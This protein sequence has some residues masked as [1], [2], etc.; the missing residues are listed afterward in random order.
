[1]KK[2]KTFLVWLIFGY[3]TTPITT[4]LKYN[5]NNLIIL[6]LRLHENSDNTFDISDYK[7]SIPNTFL[8]E[9]ERIKPFKV[10]EIKGYIF[11][12]PSMADNG[13][14][15]KI[16]FMYPF[17]FGFLG[18]EYG[19]WFWAISCCIIIN[20]Y[21]WINQFKTHHILKIK[22]DGIHNDLN[23]VEYLKILRLK[24]TL[25]RLYNFKNRALSDYENNLQEEDVRF[26][27]KIMED[28]EFLASEYSEFTR[29][30]SKF[31]IDL[32]CL[33]KKFDKQ[34]TKY[35][36]IMNLIESDLRSH[37]EKIRKV[38]EILLNG[39]V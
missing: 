15:H 34:I 31:I 35:E 17:L 10:L 8:I 23:F 33:I 11:L 28:R 27:K 26:L 24:I 38:E 37:T 7:L 2:L 3:D 29:D 39:R 18:Y 32:E 1:M 21:T 30:Y 5:R 19:L 4:Y 9:E 14:G 20:L 6:G 16:V 36:E 12:K 22:I 13:I 25:E